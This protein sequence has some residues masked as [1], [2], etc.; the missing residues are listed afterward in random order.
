MKSINLLLKLI[1]GNLLLA[2]AIILFILPPH[3]ISVGSTSLALILQ[4]STHLPYTLLV[5]I[6]NISLFVVGLICLG[7]KFALKP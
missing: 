6:I 1:L 4:A 5:Y 7:K 2:L 3:L